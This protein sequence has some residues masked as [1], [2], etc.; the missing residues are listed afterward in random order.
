MIDEDKALGHFKG[1][2]RIYPLPADGS[3]PPPR[4]LQNAPSNN[5]IELKVR[6]YIIRARGLEPQDPNGLSDPYPALKIG[7][8]KIRDRDHYVPKCLEPMY[9]LMYELDC[10]IPLESELKVQIFDYDLLSGDD[11][12]GETKIDLENRYLSA[13]RGVCGLPKRYYM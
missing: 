1:T 3:E 13:R 11:L 12:I 10:V 7:K 4:M 8:T 6:V 5:P 9:G 2:F